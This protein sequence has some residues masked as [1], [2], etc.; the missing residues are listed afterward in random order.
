MGFNYYI[1]HWKHILFHA[2]R[3]KRHC[4]YCEASGDIIKVP[5]S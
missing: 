3:V 5:L 1:L 2:R 4:C